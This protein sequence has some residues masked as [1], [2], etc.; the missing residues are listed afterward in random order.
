MPTAE[1]IDYERLA[2][3]DLAGGEIKNSVLRA[4][5]AAAREGAEIRMRHLT[6]AAAEEAAATGRVYLD[7]AST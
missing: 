7:G 1:R 3:L 2:K 5:Y 4:A 6:A